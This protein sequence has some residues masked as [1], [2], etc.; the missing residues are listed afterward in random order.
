MGERFTNQPS[1][2]RCLFDRAVAMHGLREATI[3]RYR[4]WI[5]RYLIFC[6][7]CA[8]SVSIESAKSFLQSYETFLPLR[9]K[10]FAISP[11]PTLTNKNRQRSVVCN[12]R[13]AA[14]PNAYP[15]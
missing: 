9:C 13:I 4:S 10:S 8:V 15:H 3:L 12:I 6:K 7:H 2:L 1:E 14:L 5:R 11:L